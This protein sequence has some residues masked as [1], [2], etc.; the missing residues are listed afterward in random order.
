MNVPSLL[1][2][3]ILSNVT[4]RGF[5]IRSIILA[6]SFNLDGNIAAEFGNNSAI[7]NVTI[8]VKNERIKGLT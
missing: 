3:S 7:F 6:T 1:K 4:A 5:V 8:W 2:E